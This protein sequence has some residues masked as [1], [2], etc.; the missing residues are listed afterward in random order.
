VKS[1]IQNILES[2]KSG[3]ETVDHFFQNTME[4]VQKNQ[5]KCNSFV[6]ILDPVKADK[7]VLQNV[8]YA[9]KDNFS[10]KGILTTGSSNTL[11]NYVPVYSATVY[12]KLSQAG[13]VCVG[14]TVMDEF[15]LGG[16][17]TTG[18]T[19]V[20]RNP[21]DDT[22]QA[23]GS[24]AGSAACVA[25]GVVP[26]A[27][28]TD[29]GDSIRKPA[30]FCGIVGYK[31][32]YGLISR[33]GVLPF[34]SS[35]D[36]VGVFARSVYDIALVTDV[37]KGKDERD[38]TSFD[39]SHISFVKAL[40]ENNQQPKKLFYFKELMNL[41]SYHHPS[42]QLKETFRLFDDLKKKAS[43][44]HIEICEES[45]DL[46]LLEAIPSVYTCLSC[47]E[48][49]S[50]L[51]NLTGIIFGSQEQ[52]LGKDVFE[53]MKDHRT[54]GFSPLIKRRLIIGSYVLQKENQEKYFVNAQRVR[55][56]IVE[57]M[58]HLFE[59]YDGLIL[60]CSEGGA[61]SLD[62][63]KDQVTEDLMV[64][65]NHM[66]IGNFGGFPSIT[67]PNGYV[68]GMPVGVNLT[69]KVKDDANL[70]QIAARLEKILAFSNEKERGENL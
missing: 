53:M 43:D 70:L 27:L 3:Q 45:F 48:A 69:A 25:A 35:L 38:M 63:K 33:Y 14:K 57:K 6:T 5:E 49:T 44:N 47:A 66:A 7:G 56:L 51:S 10:T 26:F 11:K 12:E 17:G 36:H 23:G 2:F 20:V 54:K 1:S 68:K 31:P 58:N 67:I 62:L 37:I 40:E 34:A 30:A 65:E 4:K 32:T 59:K 19:G 39:S 41:S 29:T 21:F 61:K 28:G 9:I 13:A 64:L 42:D 8:P 15:G 18:H 50:N 16:T 24:S 22:K 52:L 46:D 55:R 60:P